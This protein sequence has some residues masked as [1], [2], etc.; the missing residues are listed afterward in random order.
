MITPSFGLTATERVLPRMAL[1]FTTATL[2]PR[3]TFT[4][5]GNIA[6]RVNSLGL[7]ETVGANI[8]RFDFNPTTLVCKGLLIEESRTNLLVRS[9]E[10]DD[11]GW[12][13]AA[14]VTVTANT[15]IA[16]DGTLTADTVNFSGANL[17]M[18]QFPS[19]TGS[20]SGSIYMKGTAGETILFSVGSQ[21][22]TMTL[23]GDWQR[24][25]IDNIT[26]ASAISFQLSTFLGAT[27][28]TVKVWGAQA[29]AGAFSTS[30]IPTEATAV[31]RN[32]DVATMTGTNF[33]SWFNASEGAFYGE[34]VVGR[35]VSTAGTGVYAAS[36]AATNSMSMFY[37]GSG[38][39][40]AQ[41]VDGGATQADLSPTG[42][43]TA[44]QVF[45]SVL[46]YKANDFA[47][48]GNAGTVVTDATGTVPTLDRLFIGTNV[49]YLNGHVR[50]ISYYPQRL[51]NAEVQAF[52]K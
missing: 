49:N 43:L 8:P 45:K 30:Y 4:R 47:A 36:N 39:T 7:I 5:V 14:G 19:A 10:F 37:R 52:S 41:V 12:G 35:Q 26:V 1:D 9:S 2:D 34:A 25:T 32:A 46:A 15:D 33:S 44:N 27:A 13:K 21:N 28:R 18:N 48:S 23:T 50:K 42:V 51:I 16:P 31:T 17:V 22:T 24:F 3:V 11:A 20:V 38:A 40:G 29:E 6:T